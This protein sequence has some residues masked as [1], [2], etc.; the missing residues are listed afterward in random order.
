M[1]EAPVTIL[2]V[3]D[4]PENIVAL[5][6][7]LDEPGLHLVSARSGN[8]ALQV[9]LELDAALILLD[10]Q[11]PGM[12]GYETAE[13]LR[14][15]PRTRDTPIIFVTANS[16]EQRHIFRGYEAGAV[17]Y[18]T[19]PVEPL[20]LR[21][22]VQIFSQLWRQ[23]HELSARRQ[24]LA[25]ANAVL[26]QRNRELEREMDLARKV[27]LGFLPSAF[28]HP[29][30]IEFAHSYEICTTLGGDLFDVFAIDENRVG[31]YVADVAGHGVNA[32]LISGLLK[33]AV[34]N[35]RVK[36]ALEQA[37][38]DLLADPSAL[39]GDLCTAMSELI[40]DDTFITMNYSIIDVAGQTLLTAAAG[41]PYPFYLDRAAKTIRPIKIDNGPAV[42][43]GMEGD[44]AN[45]AV[46][47]ACGDAVLYY[48][49]GFTEAMNDAGEELGDEGFNE[50]VASHSHQGLGDL[51]NGI[52]E[53]VNQHRAGHPISD[54]CTLLAFCLK[55]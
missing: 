23:R 29:D 32:A 37:S 48:T 20:I 33:M 36:A 7:I 9:M 43:M 2:I 19:K 52:L 50:S 26:G 21:S 25:A 44:F 39:L 55:G 51:I 18:I 42:G 3:D 46:D 14:L 30:R 11:M 54:D 38:A 16:N 12:D 41:H 8:E 5:E 13:L 53:D 1:N 45:T 6:S 15:S 47:L 10:V 22:K 17:D 4:L 24:E 40:P 28:P 34:E 31:L 49:D 27:Q 35:I